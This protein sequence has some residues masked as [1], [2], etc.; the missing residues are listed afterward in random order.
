[1]GAF[2]GLLLLA[3]VCAAALGCQRT[4][5]QQTADA[6]GVPLPF[7]TQR[8][9]TT[10]GGVVGRDAGSLFAPPGSTGVVPAPAPAPGG[11]L[12]PGGAAGVGGATGAPG[13][14]PPR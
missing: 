11:A 6:G 14:Q 13:A 8:D 2:R 12:G 4:L 10:P 9:A 5:A 3:A 7:S 1:M